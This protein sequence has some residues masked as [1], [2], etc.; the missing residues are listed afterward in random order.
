MYGLAVFLTDL[1]PFA[2]WERRGG[3]TILLFFPVLRQ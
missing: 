2:K 1:L 3:Y